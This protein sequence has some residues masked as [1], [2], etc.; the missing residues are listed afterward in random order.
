MDH[1]EQQEEAYEAPVV[2][3]LDVAEGPSSVA[4]GQQFTPLQ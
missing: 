3:D 2:E 1:N 4:P